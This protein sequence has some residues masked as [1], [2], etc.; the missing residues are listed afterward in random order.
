MLSTVRKNDE[1]WTSVYERAHVPD[2]IV[3]AVEALG[4][5]WHLLA[6]SEDWCGDAVNLLPVL[7]RLAEKA[8]NLELRIL[9]RDENP[10]IMDAHL[11]GGTSRSIPIVILLDGD[12]EEQGWWGPRP[13]PLQAWVTEEGTALESPER[14]K[15]IRRYY[16][17]DKGRTF[18]AEIVDMIEAA[19]SQAVVSG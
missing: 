3:E 19:S 12:F 13:S 10:D 14:Y 6:L 11:T 8:E 4:G 1:L 17:Q 16:A 15:H 9:S 2:R 18:L 7:G 5:P